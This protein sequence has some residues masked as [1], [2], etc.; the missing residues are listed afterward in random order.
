MDFLYLDIKSGEIKC[1]AEGMLL[2]EVKDLWS[3]DRRTES[4]PFFHKAITFIYHMY[5]KDHVFSNSGPELRKKKVLHDFLP[6]IDIKSL[7]ENKR[8]M[9]LAG[10]FIQEQ[11]S[12]NEW[13]YEGIKKDMED[14]KKHISSIPFSKTMKVDRLI[15]VSIPSN[16]EI[17]EHEVIVKQDEVVDNS[18]EKL[19]AMEKALKLFD[20]EEK[21]KQKISKESKEKRLK[22]TSSSLLQ[23]GKFS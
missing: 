22:A 15:K 13:F 5:K 4:K 6:N 12:P 1:T 16:G 7:E 19:S 14:L 20:L 17:I 11:Y 10:R 23:S 9:K 2:L 21:I 3:A 18:G 8:V